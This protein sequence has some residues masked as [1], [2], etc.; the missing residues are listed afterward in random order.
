MEALISLNSF[1]YSFVPLMRKGEVL[2]LTV[3]LG[4]KV[5]LT[6]KDSIKV[7]PGA[8][9]KLAKDFKVET[10]K[11]HFPHY[12]NPLELHGELDWSGDIPEY[13]YFEPK[14][15]S[16]EEYREMVQQFKGPVH[17]VRCKCT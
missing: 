17:V 15:T 6:V 5:I 14:R 10:Q 9:A 1:G 3:K 13:K 4:K 8:L 11:D 7:I 2:S 16:P 12:F